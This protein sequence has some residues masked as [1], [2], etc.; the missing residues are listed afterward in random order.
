MAKEPKKAAAAKAEKKPEKKKNFFSAFAEKI[1]KFVRDCKGE[2]KRV[3]WPTVQTVFKNMGVVLVTIIAAG[4]FI[5]LLDWGFA[6]LLSL[7]MDVAG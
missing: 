7:V 4:L 1:L 3:T 5:F 6:N 2:I